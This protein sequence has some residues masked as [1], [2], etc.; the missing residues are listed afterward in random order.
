MGNGHRAIRLQGEGY[1]E[2]AARPEQPFVIET[3][4]LAVQVLGTAF[5]LRA[6]P[7]DA[8][9]ETTLVEGKVA[10]NLI[11]DP[12]RR[13]LLSPGEKLLLTR[14]NGAVPAGQ[15]DW[16]AFTAEVLQAKPVDDNPVG[17]SMWRND[18]LQLQKQIVRGTCQNHGT[19]VTTNAS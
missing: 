1:F 4:D 8:S 12:A 9:L 14:R 7:E 2:V 5:N 6:Y 18:R 13:Q 10:V 15:Q 19:L 16:G 11:S 17:E 3:A